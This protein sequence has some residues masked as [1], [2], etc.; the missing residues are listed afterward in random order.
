MAQNDP[1]WSAFDAGKFKDGAAVGVA[2]GSGVNQTGDIGQVGQAYRMVDSSTPRFKTVIN[3]RTLVFNASGTVVEAFNPVL[4]QNETAPTLMALDWLIEQKPTVKMDMTRAAGGEATMSST[5]LRD[6]MAMQCLN[7]IM[8]SIVKPADLDDAAMFALSG[9]AYRWAEAMM[10]TAANYRVNEAEGSQETPDPTGDIAGA[11]DGLKDG[12]KIMNVGGSAN[13][14]PLTTLTKVENP[15]A[16]DEEEQAYVPVPLEVHVTGGGGGGGTTVDFTDL[17]EAL[18]YDAGDN[19]TQV[20]M[21]NQLITA[22][23]NAG[24]IDKDDVAPVSNASYIDY[25]LAFYDYQNYKQPVKITPS[26]LFNVLKPHL[27][28][29]YGLLLENRNNGLPT[30]LVAG[31]YYNVTSWGSIVL[32]GSVSVT[33]P[34]LTNVT[35]DYPLL[36]MAYFMTPPAA[37]VGDTTVTFA[38]NGNGKPVKYKGGSL[39][40]LNAQTWY[41]IDFVFNGT[42]WIVGA[43]VTVS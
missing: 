43:T 26:V 4:G 37:T 39:A 14:V 33:L 27:D 20:S 7:A 31:R 41:E 21:L 8:Q 15:K 42:C 25:I 2:V 13:P 17:I 29:K 12:V 35:V 28:P 19:I 6:Q 30:P 5:T 36:I 24:K 11:I 34:D 9:V 1:Q 3:G 16:Y 40:T 38:V 22:V 32:A 10:R 18:G 23:N